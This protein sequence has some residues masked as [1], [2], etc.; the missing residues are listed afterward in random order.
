MQATDLKGLIAWLKANPDKA[1][2]GTVGVHHDHATIG[3]KSLRSN[4]L[5][6]ALRGRIPTR[7]SAVMRAWSKIKSE[8]VSP[9]TAASGQ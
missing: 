4:K 9:R 2:Q 7:G 1:S 5:W 3:L 8:M 6:D